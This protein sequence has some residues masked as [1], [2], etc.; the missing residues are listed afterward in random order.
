MEHDHT[1]TPLIS[2]DELKS[3]V[4]KAS[5]FRIQIGD[6]DP[7]LT[8]VYINLAVLGSALELA[9]DLQDKIAEQISSLPAAA[10]REMK[11]AGA[12]VT[13]ILAKDVGRLANQI[14]GDAAME[15][16]ALA[17]SR[18]MQW[19]A[20]GVL[21]CSVVFFS[22]GY[23]VRSGAEA[24][25]LSAQRDRVKEAQNRADAAA[26]VADEKAGAEIDAI[27]RRSGWAATPDGRLAKQFF[28]SGAG[29]IA[30]KCASVTWDI[31]DRNDE[32]FC[33]PKR[34]DLIGGDKSKHGWKIP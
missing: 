9:G 20:G 16:K 28:D 22:T 10:E 26:A 19:A 14:A 6:N 30:A 3:L 15:A 24:V 33:V 32:K 13:E 21:A 2:I 34:R 27:R 29:L 17:I 5:G 31:V 11:R 18:A 8:T 4:Y 1:I 23:L 25:N 7:L 12:T